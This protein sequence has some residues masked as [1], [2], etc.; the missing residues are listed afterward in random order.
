MSATV[1][2]RPSTYDQVAQIV[3]GVPEG[4]WT[5][6]PVEERAAWQAVRMVRGRK[7]FDDL[8][9]NIDK[10]TREEI[11]QSLIQIIDGEYEREKNQT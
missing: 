11:F 1:K 2:T 7:G 4:D 9:D 3:Y 5:K 8:W 6:L 10:E